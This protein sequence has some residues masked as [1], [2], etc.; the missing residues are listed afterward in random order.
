ESSR[1]HSTE[2]P[3]TLRSSTAY[4]VE[5]SLP[6]G[7][8]N[9]TVSPN[10]GGKT[11]SPGPPAGCSRVRERIAAAPPATAADRTSYVSDGWD[12]LPPR[13]GGIVNC[14]N[15]V[16]RHP[17]WRCGRTG[18]DT[19]A[20]NRQARRRADGA[21]HASMR[22]SHRYTISDVRCGTDTF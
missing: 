10:V 6:T 4:R 17:V 20:R 18:G 14:G 12:I 13:R 2:A 5:C 3:F 19:V 9:R 16:Q 8:V 22:P 1:T 21:A 7:R 15:R 11:L